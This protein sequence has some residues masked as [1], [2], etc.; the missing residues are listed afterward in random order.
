MGGHQQEN[1]RLPDHAGKSGAL[2]GAWNEG[3]ELK[4]A[5]MCER[6]FGHTVFSPV[7]PR[8]LH[9]KNTRNRAV[10]SHLLLGVQINRVSQWGQKSAPPTP[11]PVAMFDIPEIRSR[12][13]I[14]RM[15]S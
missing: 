1:Q 12:S 6:K 13:P 14:H 15:R 8:A 2:D 9:F 3:G 4:F 7:P 11:S 5:R 10:P